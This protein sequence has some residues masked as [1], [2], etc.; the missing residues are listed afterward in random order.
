MQKIALK[1]YNFIELIWVY[2]ALKAMLGIRPRKD[3]AGTHEVADLLV[4][5]CKEASSTR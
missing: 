1:N 2:I 3:D 5:L 4:T